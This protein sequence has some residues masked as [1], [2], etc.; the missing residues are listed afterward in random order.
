[1][2]G[3][4]LAVHDFGKLVVLNEKGEQV[5]LSSLWRRRTAVFVF[6]RHFG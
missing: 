5:K 1:M 4:N 2:L 3:Q 6:V